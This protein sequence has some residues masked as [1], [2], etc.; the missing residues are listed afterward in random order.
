MLHNKLLINSCVATWLGQCLTTLLSL[1]V[2]HPHCVISSYTYDPLILIIVIVR[3]AK[4]M[5]LTGSL[6]V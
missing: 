3:V 4:G 2:L 1:D 5:H 6:D